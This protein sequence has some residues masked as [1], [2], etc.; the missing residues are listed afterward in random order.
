VNLASVTVALD[1]SSNYGNG[2]SLANGCTGTIA[3][4]TVDTDK[5]DGVH[6]QAGAHDVTVGGGTVTCSGHTPTAHQ[7]GMQATNGTN[8]L[9]QHVAFKCATANN[10][11]FFVNWISKNEVPTGIVCDGCTLG[12]TM[13]KTVFIGVNSHQSGVKNSTICRSPFADRWNSPTVVR[14]NNTYVCP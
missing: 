2:I 7:D 10:A 4:I 8:I 14:A 11:Q 5:S 3:S 13:G 9:F 1:A 12:R 6:V